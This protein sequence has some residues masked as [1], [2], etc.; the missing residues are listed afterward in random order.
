MCVS[1]VCVKGKEGNNLW[2]DGVWRVLTHAVGREH[3]CD[4]ANPL[5]AW[6]SSGSKERVLTVV[7]LAGEVAFLSGDQTS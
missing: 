5:P 3:V 1:K 6:S 4:T 7:G 2:Q